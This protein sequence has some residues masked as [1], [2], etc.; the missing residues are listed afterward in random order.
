LSILREMAKALERLSDRQ[1]DLY[2]AIEPVMGFA[3]SYGVS[4]VFDMAVMEDLKSSM[5]SD[6]DVMD[7]ESRL[8]YVDGNTLH[9]LKKGIRN[10]NID[11]AEYARRNLGNVSKT[12]LDSV[13]SDHKR[14]AT[15]IVQRAAVDAIERANVEISKSVDGKT[16]EVERLQNTMSSS[17]AH[18]L[19]E[20]NDLK[21]SFRV[22]IKQQVHDEISEVNDVVADKI[23]KLSQRSIGLLA[24]VEG[25][26][27]KFR[28]AEDGLK[29]MFM[30]IN[31]IESKVRSH[32]EAAFKKAIAKT[33]EMIAVSTGNL[34]KELASKTDNIQN[35]LTR[36]E[37]VRAS[38]VVDY[39]KALEPKVE[40][41][42]DTLKEK[43][44]ALK[45]REGELERLGDE[46]ESTIAKTNRVAARVSN[47]VPKT[48]QKVVINVKRNN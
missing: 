28:S 5:L 19:S 32:L 26:H 45:N 24:E 10:D 43:I 46:I 18:A 30:E 3:A 31:G 6:L 38:T 34:E 42:K 47:L 27:A 12:Q 2:K 48:K 14:D 33:D 11:G 13:M 41:L 22:D 1:D 39:K 20:I 7:Q 35:L 44:E 4:Q 23:E 16:K 9:L 36:V 37:E 15:R 17:L 25:Y 40:E 8:K 29:V 21:D